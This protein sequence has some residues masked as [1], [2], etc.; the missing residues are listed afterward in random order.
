MG[1]LQADVSLGWEDSWRVR[2][3][4]PARG[5]EVYWGCGESRGPKGDPWM[6]TGPNP[7]RSLTPVPQH[8]QMSTKPRENLQ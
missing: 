6:A 8:V 1:G 4:P 5:I 3:T 2:P 7:A